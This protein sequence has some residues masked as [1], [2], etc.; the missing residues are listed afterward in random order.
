MVEEH[1][2]L[3]TFEESISEVGFEGT[4]DELLKS[5]FPPIEFIVEDFFPKKSIS[6]IFGE[7][8]CGKTW[9]A[10]Y[11]A[12]C[13]ASGKPVFEILNTKK[14]KVMY[15]EE[16]NGE[17]RIKE[18]IGAL[19]KGHNIAEEDLKNLKIFSFKGLSIGEDRWVKWMRAKI[20][21]FQPEIVIVDSL[22]AVYF[23]DQLNVSNANTIRY[24]AT[25]LTKINDCNICIVHH[26]PKNRSMNGKKKPMGMEDLFGSV[27]FA[28]MASTVIGV[29]KVKADGTEAFMT[30]LL[31]YRDGLGRKAENFFLISDKTYNPT[32]MGILYGGPVEEVY[33]DKNNAAKEDIIKLL[34]E[35]SGK[36]WQRKE[37]IERLNGIHKTSPIDAGLKMLR[38]ESKYKLLMD[39]TTGKYSWKA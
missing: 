30:K 4:A 35:E 22:S 15:F 10:L 6:Y 2:K 9:W 38:E 32:S 23:D 14:C 24:W 3:K 39:T 21:E 7:P 31:K 25:N 29:A 26:S 5:N 33:K 1:P 13:C 11:V 8:G 19:V 20:K 27:Q 16:E 36:V 12:L 18:R 17:G 28:G 34:K 37:I